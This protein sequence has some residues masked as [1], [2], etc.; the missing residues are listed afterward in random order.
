MVLNSLLITSVLLL[1]KSVSF[2]ISSTYIE[3][4]IECLGAMSDSETK[5]E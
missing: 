2:G 3:R 4:G 1:M 5:I